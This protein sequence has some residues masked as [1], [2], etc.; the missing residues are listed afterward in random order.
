MQILR[1]F[2]ET[3]T[4]KDGATGGRRSFAEFVG[5]GEFVEDG[6]RDGYDGVRGG[7]KAGEF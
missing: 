7:G 3:E 1:W 2:S 6:A 5:F 4:G